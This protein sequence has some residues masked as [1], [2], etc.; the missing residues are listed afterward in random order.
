M[1][2]SIASAAPQDMYRQDAASSQI[3][4]TAHGTQADA[5]IACS[6]DLGGHLRGASVQVENRRSGF[7]LS[8]LF[9]FGLIEYS[10]VLGRH[11]QPDGTIIRPYKGE[12]LGT[13]RDCPKRK[14]V[15]RALEP[16]LSTINSPTYRARPTATFAEFSNRWEAV[17]LS[18]HKPSTQS[19]TRS[20]LRKWLRPHLGNRLLKDLGGL[21][22]QAFVS[23]HVIRIRSAIWWRRLA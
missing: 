3:T 9:H 21:C 23:A 22:L 7:D 11:A 13:I 12:V 18:Q 15:L 4:L 6:V 19:S 17:V 5:P 8:F 14:L 2:Y 20:Q 10:W 1:G 16:R